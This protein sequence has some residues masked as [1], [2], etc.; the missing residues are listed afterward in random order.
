MTG[1]NGLFEAGVWELFIPLIELKP[2]MNRRTKRLVNPSPWL[3]L[4]DRD[5]WHRRKALT[6]YYREAAINAAVEA[7]L[8]GMDAAHM[9]AWIC[10]GNN[11]RLDPHNYTLTAKACV[12]GLIEYGWLP[13]DCSKFLTGPDMRRDESLPKGL[14]LRIFGS[15]GRFDERRV[16]TV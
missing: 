16:H 7:D 8:P 15:G 14:T 11:R 9:E 5:S 1:F 6:V 10:Y 12:D 13:D 2:R 3:T 4:N